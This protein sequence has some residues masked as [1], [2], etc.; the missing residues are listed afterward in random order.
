M[1]R[2]RTGTAEYDALLRNST[3]ENARLRHNEAMVLY[4]FGVCFSIVQFV[5]GV[6]LA[7]SDYECALSEQLSIAYL[8]GALLAVTSMLGYHLV[9]NS[10]RSIVFTVLLVLHLFWIGVGIWAIAVL[11]ISNCSVVGVQWML[12][13]DLVVLVFAV[14]IFYKY[15]VLT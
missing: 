15:L 1:L 9:H 13:I 4:F 5:D 8:S 14:G 3:S 10:G 11:F 2:E 7:N 12:F 6:L